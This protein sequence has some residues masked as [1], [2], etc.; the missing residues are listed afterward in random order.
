MNVTLK[1]AYEPP[2]S[3]DGYRV[4]VDR[5]WPRG[6]SK[7]DARIDA[8]PKE[9]APS[10]ELRQS[11]HDGRLGWGEFRRRYMTEL[12]ARRDTLRELAERAREGRVTLVF[13][14][15]DERHNNAVVLKQYLQMLRR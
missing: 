12:K 6:I 9:V 7:A 14:S 13:S 8:W 3:Q 15:K 11:F 10:D 5:L 4:L 1:R 2:S